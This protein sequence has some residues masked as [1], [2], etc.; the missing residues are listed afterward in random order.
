MET[1]CMRLDLGLC[2]RE[3]CVLGNP[4]AQALIDRERLGPLLTPRSIS[5]A[6]NPPMHT[7]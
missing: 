3:V 1:L 6:F 2:R 4:L 7:K 5:C